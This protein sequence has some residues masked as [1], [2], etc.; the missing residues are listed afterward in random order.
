[1][2]DLRRRKI[3]ARSAVLGSLA[4]G[5]L[6][7]GATLASSQTT[8][9]PRPGPLQPGRVAAPQAPAQAFEL[10]SSI[11]PANAATPIINVVEFE[12]EFTRRLNE[13]I[14]FAPAAKET[15]LVNTKV[16]KEIVD[17]TIWKTTDAIARALTPAE[18]Q[19]LRELVNRRVDIAIAGQM[20]GYPA[21]ASLGQGSIGQ[22]FFVG[23]I[24]PNRDLKL[25]EQLQ[26]QPQLPMATNF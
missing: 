18:L 24:L 4:F 6:L 26:L 11:L 3:L 25:A 10:K 19:G 2:A 20:R 13:V 15:T 5:M 7:F 12:S 22:D 8:P 23:R 17:R 16:Y 9:P 14:R 21:L 1:M